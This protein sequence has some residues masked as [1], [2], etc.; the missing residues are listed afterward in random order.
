M[1]SSRLDQQKD[2]TFFCKGCQ[3]HLIDCREKTREEIKSIEEVNFCGIFREEQL[4]APARYTC[5]N[6]LLFLG[7]TGLSILGFSVQPLKAQTQDPI[8]VDSI[9]AQAEQHQEVTVVSV[10]EPQD[11]LEEETETN[12]SFYLFDFLRSPRRKKKRSGFGPMGCP[13]F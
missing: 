6:R 4:D 10:D 1:A 13:K 12:K 8:Q 3:K 9:Q 11:D 7:L 5:F 2:G